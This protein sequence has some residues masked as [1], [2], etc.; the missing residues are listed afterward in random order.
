MKGG[1]KIKKITLLKLLKEKIINEYLNKYDNFDIID[2]DERRKV[3]KK[4]KK[5]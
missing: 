5:K 1:T 4:G 2:L 3:Y